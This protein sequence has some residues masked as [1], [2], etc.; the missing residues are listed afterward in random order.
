MTHKLLVI[1]LL[2]KEVSIIRCIALLPIVLRNNKF[3]FNK[4]LKIVIKSNLK[5][6]LQY[7]NIF[8]YI[9]RSTGKKYIY[10]LILYMFN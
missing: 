3:I 2:I 6:V 7:Y 8:R 5:I 4:I 10:S 1:I 9:L